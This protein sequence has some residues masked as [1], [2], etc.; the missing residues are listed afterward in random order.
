MEILSFKQAL[1]NLVAQLREKQGSSQEALA[2]EAGIDHLTISEIERGEVNPTIDILHKVSLA[3]KQTLGALI[4]QSEEIASGNVRQAAPTANSSYINHNIPLP[5][6]LTHNQLEAALNRAMAILDQI[7]LDPDAGDIQANIYSGVV[8][9]IVTKAIAEVSDFVQNKDTQH[10][11][12][13]DPRLPKGHR[14]WGLE[15]KATKQMNKGGESHNPGHG[16]FMIVVYQVVKGKTYIV[17]VEVA[18]LEREDWTIHDRNPDSNRTRTAVTKDYATQRLR[19]N[20]VYLD[21]DYVT[22]VRSAAKN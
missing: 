17:Q 2:L 1:G 18:E 10:P 8:S 3:L 6:G 4:I 22:S 19:A 14:D 11:D 7:G 15:M 5:Q 13:F 16:W 12:L 20:S 9:N 21:P